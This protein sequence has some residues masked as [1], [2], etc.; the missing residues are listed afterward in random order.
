MIKKALLLSAGFGSRLKPFTL[1]RPKCLTLINGKCVLDYWIES[2]V[3]SGID[4]VYVNTHWLSDAVAQHISNSEWVELITILHEPNILGTAGTIRANQNIFGKENLLVAH[5]DNLIN[6]DIVKFIASL[7]GRPP[8]AVMSMLCF[9]SSQ[10][11]NVGIV[12]RDSCN[13]V[14]EFHEKCDRAEYGN[15]ANAAV[16]ILGGD[17]L[18]F[19][20][21]LSEDNKDLSL[22]VIPKL[23]GK[24]HSVD[25]C[26]YLKDIGTP[27]DLLQ[28]RS[29]FFTE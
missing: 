29:D 9:R 22:H 10:P 8:E 19:I 6:F 25:V 16:Y 3:S 12:V 26:G 14:R 2:L 13:I 1:T 23:I 15:I 4:K 5:A 28:A 7:E 21:N 11:E 18:N 17:A 24:I 20:Y 27:A